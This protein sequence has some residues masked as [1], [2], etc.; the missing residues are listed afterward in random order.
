MVRH[1]MLPNIARHSLTVEKVAIA[2]ARALIAVGEKINCAEVQ[3]GALLHDITKTRSIRTR[4][5]HAL[6][7]ELFLQ[8][9]G[10]PRIG[11]VVRCHVELPPTLLTGPV[12]PELVVNY[13]DKRVLHEKIVALSCRFQDLI[14]R[15][16]K[17]AEARRRL[18]FL[19]TQTLRIEE[20]IFSLISFGPEDLPCFVGDGGKAVRSRPRRQPALEQRGWL[21]GSRQC[22]IHTAAHTDESLPRKTGLV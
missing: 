20:R 12:S 6:T 14:E 7:G 22:D 18:R 1:G 13:A 3:A 15:Y 11:E 8:N 21:P 9:A 10:Y 2:V 4:E 5:N 17:T 19:E 16:G